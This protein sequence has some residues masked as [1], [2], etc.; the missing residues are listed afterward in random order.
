MRSEPEF[1]GIVLAAGAGRRFGDT[2]KQL[3]QV[4]GAPLLQHA[5]DAVLAVP[6]IWPVAVVLGA[7]A[8]EI[9]VAVDFGDAQVVVCDDWD[10]GLAASLRA[11]ADA[12]GVGAEWLVVLLGDQ[13]G[14]T[15][16]IVAMVVDYALSSGPRFGAVRAT[17]DGVPGHPVALSTALLPEFSRLRGDR[18]ARDLLQGLRVRE[19]EAGHLG[20]AHDIDTPEDL[21]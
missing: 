9:R 8:D 12:V 5:V 3:A 1:A 17:Y 15:P 20:S 13:P 10:E 19:V 18:G 14:V 4:R 16:Q 21:P 7:R 11:G 6:A 2:P